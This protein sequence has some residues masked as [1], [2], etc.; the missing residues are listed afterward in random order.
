MKRKKWFTSLLLALLITMVTAFP[1]MAEEKIGLKVNGDAVIFATPHLIDGHS[2]IPAAFFARFSGATLE[3][4]SDGGLNISQGGKVLTMTI[5]SKEAMLGDAAAALPVA[6]FTRGEDVFVP[7]RFVGEAFGYEVG[8]DGA[9]RM[10]SLT[11]SETRDGLGLMDILAKS[12]Q[13]G[14]SANTYTMDG[15]ANIK[16][17]VSAN[18]VKI[19][20]APLDITTKITG[21]IQNDPMKIYMKQVIGPVMAGMP[22]MAVEMYMTGEKMYMKVPAADGTE[23]VWMAQKM[24][25]PAEFFKQ[26]QDIQSDPLKAAQQMKELGVLMNFGDDTVIDGKAYYVINATLDI[27]KFREGYEKMM[28]QALQ[29]MPAAGSPD[30]MQQQTMKLMET[31]NFDYYYTVYVNKET[32]ITDIVKFKFIMDF[33]MSVPAGE[34]MPAPV[35]MNMN[36]NMDMKG[37]FKIKALGEP[38]KAPDVSKAVEM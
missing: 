25:V 10:V 38:F 9:Q 37:D 16:M 36:M 17:A 19:N 24:P 18:G 6:P 4:K 34:D 3:R 35:E 31:A 12:T 30:E 15:L 28:R 29:G 22:E 7:L 1:A 27:N 13:A 11:R 33:A 26:Q 2:M 14:L 8:W 5:G 21:Q 32:F 20:E 23:P